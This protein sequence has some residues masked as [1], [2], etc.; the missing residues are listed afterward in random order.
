MSY[1]YIV[2]L[3]PPFGINFPPPIEIPYS[4]TITKLGHERPTTGWVGVAPH[5]KEKY[6][7]FTSKARKKKEKKVFWW[8]YRNIAASK[9]SAGKDGP[10]QVSLLMTP[11]SNTKEEQQWSSLNSINSLTKHLSNQTCSLLSCQTPEAT[12]Q[13]FQGNQNPVIYTPPWVLLDSRWTLDLLLVDSW[14]TPHF[15][16]LFFDMNSMVMPVSWSN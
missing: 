5:K 6:I 10:S 7:Y 1:L 8:N 9:G 13:S 2:A 15:L 14:W 12:K 11:I 16:D 4:I 3:K